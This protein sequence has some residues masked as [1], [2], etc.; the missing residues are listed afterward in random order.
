MAVGISECILGKVRLANP[1]SELCAIR[2]GRAT[3]TDGDGKQTTFGP[4]DSL[5]IAQSEA[6]TWDVQE[7]VQKAFF[8]HIDAG[9]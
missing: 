3:V 8:L 1:F 7:A 2:Q 5:F 4:G 9:A 6:S